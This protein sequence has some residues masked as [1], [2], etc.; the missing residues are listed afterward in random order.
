MKERLERIAV[1]MIVAG[2]GLSFAMT[3]ALVVLICIHVMR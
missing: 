1:A 3:G 2:F